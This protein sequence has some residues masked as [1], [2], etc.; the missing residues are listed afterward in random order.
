[1][2]FTSA[3][4]QPDMMTEYI[5]CNNAF[6]FH[7]LNDPV[8]NQYILLHSIGHKRHTHGDV[9]PY[10]WD[11][12]DERPENLQ[13]PMCIFQYTVSGEGI[14]E[15]QSRQHRVTAGTAFLIERPGNYRYWLPED[16][17]HWEVKYV[18]LSTTAFPLWN[19]LVQTYGRLFPVTEKDALLQLWEKIYHKAA[20]QRI[21]DIFENTSLAYRLLVEIH[22]QCSCQGLR[23]T[24]ADPVRRCVQ[25]IEEHYDEDLSLPDIAAAGNL[26]P[27]RVNLV[28]KAVMRDSP[29][30][31]LNKLRI[32][33]SAVLL[34]NTPMTITEIAR[35]CGFQNANYFSKVFRKYV[36]IPPSQFRKQN[37]SPLIL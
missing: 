36:G 33:T 3:A 34:H 11:C 29:I 23:S 22:R 9:Q 21:P 18:C 2:S 32:R 7:F 13:L 10:R 4:P 26:S 19:A 17:D 35:Q 25:F 27:Y 12:S 20:E 16:A 8:L 6:V 1:M 28:F 15:I 30:H 24:Y 37:V 14:V 5:D 31:Y